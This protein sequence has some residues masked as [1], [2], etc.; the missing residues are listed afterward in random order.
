LTGIET[1]KVHFVKDSGRSLACSVLD[2]LVDNRPASLMTALGEIDTAPFR[3]INNLAPPATATVITPAPTANAHL[4]RE[5]EVG[6]G[7]P[8]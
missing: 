6:D 1:F 5:R 2:G 7:I 8:A 4:R 3:N